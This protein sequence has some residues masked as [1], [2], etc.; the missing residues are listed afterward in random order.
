MRGENEGVQNS[1][2][3]FFTTALF[4][5][6]ITICFY[7]HFTQTFEGPEDGDTPLKVLFPEELEDIQFIK[8]IP[9]ETNNDEPVSMQLEILGCI[10]ESKYF[11]FN[12]RTINT[13]I[14]EMGCV[15]VI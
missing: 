8:I 9:T 11:C 4:L 7:Y 6:V 2:S 3:F 1:Q 13:F 5:F 10:E 12:N 15:I 14:V